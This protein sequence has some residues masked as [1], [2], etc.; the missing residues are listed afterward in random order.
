MEKLT[1]LTETISVTPQ[2]TPSDIKEIAELGFKSVINNRPDHEQAE[3]PL[4]SDIEQSAI[5]M[6][7]KFVHLPIVAGKVTAGQC[8]QFTQLLE[9]LPK[10]ILAFCRTGTR[11]TA[12]WTMSSNDGESFAH[13]MGI[14]KSL[15]FDLNWVSKPEK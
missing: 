4:N 13:R 6:G 14:A 3:Q 7:L 8:Q 1:Q 12:I 15:G 10:P 5:S 11:S 9:E 2:I